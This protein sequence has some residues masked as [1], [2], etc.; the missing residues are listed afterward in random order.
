[1]WLYSVD[2]VLAFNW[3]RYLQFCEGHHGAAIKKGPDRFRRK[4]ADF[5]FVNGWAAQRAFFDAF[6]H[7][8]PPLHGL[9]PTLR[10][11]EFEVADI[12]NGKLT[13]NAV[14]AYLGSLLDQ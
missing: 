14:K 12:L 1:L 4:T 11:A 3:N 5:P 9:R 6:R 10:M 2:N 13:G 7:W 8:L